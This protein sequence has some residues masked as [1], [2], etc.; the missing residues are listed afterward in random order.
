MVKTYNEF[1]NK[2]MYYM[3]RDVENILSPSI[4]KKNISNYRLLL[5]EDLLAIK[6]FYPN[7]LAT[8]DSVL[9]Y[10]HGV[11]DISLVKK[12][13][14]SLCGEIAKRCDVLVIAIDYDDPYKENNN[15]KRSY[16]TIK[17]I[18]EGIDFSN[19][20]VGGDSYGGILSMEV[21]NLINKKGD[22]SFDKQILLY[23]IVK[24]DNKKVNE[25]INVHIEYNGEIESDFIDNED[26]LVI[27]GSMDIMR[28][29]IYD[30][31]RDES[32]YL[33]NMASHG[34]MSLKDSELRDEVYTVIN[35][36]K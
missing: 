35:K 4:S 13:Y 2:E 17:K 27:V 25:L 18:C 1:D 19:V 30:K 26:T 5:D 14:S 29:V 10:F 22:F 31:F 15:V 12:G 33:V 24:V 8:I 3:Y 32:I 36:F 6:V 28:D 11:G 34:F 23:P 9:F 21:C 7:K 16:D 20:Y